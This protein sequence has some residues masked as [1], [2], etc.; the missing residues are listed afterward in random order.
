MIAQLKHRGA[1]ICTM[2]QLHERFVII[3]NSIVWYGDIN[4]LIPAKKEEHIMR[5]VTPQLAKELTF[6]I[7]NQ[8]HPMHIQQYLPLL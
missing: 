3:D 1:H 2:P 5:L 7:H 4:P 6:H 8:I